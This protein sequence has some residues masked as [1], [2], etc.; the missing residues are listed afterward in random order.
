M[1]MIINVSFWTVCEEKLTCSTEATFLTVSS[2]VRPMCVRAVTPG[3]PKWTVSV[4][5]SVSTTC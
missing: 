2:H 3:F 4:I 5:V 1:L